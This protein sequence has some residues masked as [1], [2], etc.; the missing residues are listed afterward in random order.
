MDRDIKEMS[1]FVGGWFLLSLLFTPMFSKL[2]DIPSNETSL[3]DRLGVAFTVSFMVIGFLYILIL[4]ILHVR[5]E[6]LNQA[7]FNTALK[8]A[9]ELGGNNVLGGAGNGIFYRHWT[10]AFTVNGVS[11]TFHEEHGWSARQRSQVAMTAT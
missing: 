6:R 3:T 8:I 11:H 2:L 5:Q 4:I 7:S 9:R 1:E 10:L